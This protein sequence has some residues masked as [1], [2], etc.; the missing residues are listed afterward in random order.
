MMLVQK[1]Q[2]DINYKLANKKQSIPLS[3]ALNRNQITTPISIATE[4]HQHKLNHIQ[5]Q[6]I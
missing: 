5:D 2:S 6:R 3:T 4:T 1:R